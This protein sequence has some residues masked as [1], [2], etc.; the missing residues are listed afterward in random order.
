MYDRAKRLKQ[1]PEI[2]SLDGIGYA[3]RVQ[4]PT[5]CNNHYGAKLSLG[6]LQDKAGRTHEK[7]EKREKVCQSMRAHN[8]MTMPRGVRRKR[9]RRRRRRSTQQKE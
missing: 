8:P 5:V 1:I 3:G 9:R 6:H 2:I 4:L 7:E